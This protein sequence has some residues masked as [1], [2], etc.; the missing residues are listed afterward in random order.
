MTTRY[1][2]DGAGGRWARLRRGGAAL[3]VM[4]AALASIAT[5]PPEWRVED[6]I[7]GLVSDLHASQP[8]D[9]RLFTARSSHPH[10]VRVAAT[11]RWDRAIAD[12]VA[13]VRVR[14][15]RHDGEVLGER[16]ATVDFDDRGAPED[17]RLSLGSVDGCPEAPCEASYRVDLALVDG[18]PTETVRVEWSFTAGFSGDGAHQPDGAFVELTEE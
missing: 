1:G 14:I 3:A 2:V 13:A 11:L 10:E 9:A 6:S 18:H 7:D 16:T 12:P 8:E 17:T 5:S 4:A 15:T